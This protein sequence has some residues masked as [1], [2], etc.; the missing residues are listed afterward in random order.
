MDGSLTQLCRFFEAAQ[1]P[2]NPLALATILRTEGSTYRKAGAHILIGQ[3]GT[4]SSLLSG[5]CLEGELRDHALRTISEMR[6]QRVRFDTRNDDPLWGIGMGCE[7]AMDV[8]IEPV[9]PANAFGPLPYFRQCLAQAHA[10]AVATVVGG[11]AGAAEL[12]R[13][14]AAGAAAVD[15]LG[16][17]LADWAGGPPGLS[18]RTFDGRCLQVFVNKVTLPAQILLCGAGRDAMPVCE[19]AAA[20][21]WLVS[22]ADHRPALAQPS[23]FPSARRVVLAHPDELPQHLDLASFDAGIIMSHHLASDVRYLDLLSRAP[24]RYIGLLGPR[25]RRE[26]ILADLGRPLGE[27]ESRL[28]GPVGLDLGA[29]TPEGIALSIVAQIHAHLAQRAGGHFGRRA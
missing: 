5:G 25:A 26:K 1:R 7:G 23:S 17:A 9:M 2:D 15:A 4:S 28:F 21:G 22:V 20:L 8:W 3:D 12:G 27:A 6:G 10:G 29:T 18:E 19:A 13:F 24:M 11:D 14:G 16:K